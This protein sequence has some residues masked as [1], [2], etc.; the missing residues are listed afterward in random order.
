MKTKFLYRVLSHCKES[1][2]EFDSYLGPEDGDS[3]RALA[4]PK[5]VSVTKTYRSSTGC[6]AFPPTPLHGL[7]EA[8]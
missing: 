7:T 4:G 6:N 5:F 3:V 1:T 8:S 2:Y